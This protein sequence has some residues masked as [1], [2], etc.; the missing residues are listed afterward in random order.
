MRARG[1]NRKSE[2][3]MSLERSALDWGTPAL[4]KIENSHYGKIEFV[5]PK[6]TPWEETRR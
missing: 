2:L 1:P 5:P 6:E 3:E 4:Q